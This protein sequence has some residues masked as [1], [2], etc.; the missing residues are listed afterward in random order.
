MGRV[1]KQDLAHGQAAQLFLDFESA[2]IKA[3]TFS[4]KSSCS[5]EEMPL[6]WF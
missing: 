3:A 5:V 2:A 1:R 4:D 6:S